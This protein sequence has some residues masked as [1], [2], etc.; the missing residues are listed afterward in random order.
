M[1]FVTV[2]RFCIESVVWETSKPQIT[3]DCMGAGSYGRGVLL[4]EPR[5]SSPARADSDRDNRRIPPTPPPLFKNTP[6][7]WIVLSN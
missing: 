4:W 1:K 7:K 6:I 2:D 3:A 5:P